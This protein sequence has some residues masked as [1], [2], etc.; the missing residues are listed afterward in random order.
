MAI[1]VIEE[2]NRC[3]QCKVPRCQQGCPI[4]T[5]I[6]E[7]IRL[8]KENQVEEAAQMLFENNPLSVVCSLVCDHASQCE[9]HCVRGLKGE[10]VHISSIENYI[11]DSALERVQI[12]KKADNGMKAAVIGAGPAG[13]TISMILASRGY[14]VTLFESRDK[15]G[16][17]MRYGIPE[18]R[19]PH[20]I[21]DRIALKMKELG[22]L[23]RPNFSIG[24]N[25][26]LT[27][28]FKDGYKS[29]F[30]GT[31]AWRP[32]RMMIPGE[33]FGNVHYGINYLNN[34]D[35]VNLGRSTAIFGAGNSAMDVARTAV[36]KGCRDVTV[37]VRR[38]KVAAN[39]D[40]YELA[41]IDGVKFAFNKIAIEI[42]DEGPVI[43]DTIVTEDGKVEILRE[44]AQLVPT[45]SVVIAVSQV[46]RHRIVDNNKDLK[47]NERGNLAVDEEGE[48]TMSG[49]FASG[50]VVTGAK[51]VVHAVEDAKKIADEM[52]HYMQGL[53]Q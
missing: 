4:H 25:V 2:A 51:T 3:L 23:Y 46:P 26:T 29:I 36:R 50:D 28:L 33:T 10:P 6:P 43:C 7:M 39:E 5:N 12:P 35:S 18:F 17:I 48:T 53:D 37:Y 27:D 38:N 21:L 52:D 34:P 42:K 22:I 41:K 45:D 19:L 9:G 31:G 49:V 40:E 8:F 32:R 30:I 1:H 11:S 44:T 15:I 24:G 16:G 14:K 47:L 20:S 13:I